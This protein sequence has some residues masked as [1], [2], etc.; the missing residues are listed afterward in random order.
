MLHVFKV[1]LL[2]IEGHFPV[3]WKHIM[4]ELIFTKKGDV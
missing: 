3:R 1:A 4:G 2:T